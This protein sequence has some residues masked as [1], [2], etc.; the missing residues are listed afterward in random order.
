M[1]TFETNQCV[2][3]AA[4]SRLSPQ[5]CGNNPDAKLALTTNQLTVETVVVPPAV[6]VVTVVVRPS[7]SAVIPPIAI[8]PPTIISLISA[9]AV[10]M[11][12]IAEPA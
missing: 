10:P 12:V 4:Y 1:F 7:T 5:T 9:A 11:I 8:V 2:V 3:R 6:P